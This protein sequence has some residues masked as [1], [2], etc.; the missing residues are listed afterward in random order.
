MR[1]IRVIVRDMHPVDGLRVPRLGPLH[2]RVLSFRTYGCKR[3][4]L[5]MGSPARRRLQPDT[6][7]R[8]DIIEPS[9]ETPLGHAMV[10]EG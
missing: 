3:I 6:P 5:A 1:R 8:V 4:Y 2:E 10:R 9:A 7:G